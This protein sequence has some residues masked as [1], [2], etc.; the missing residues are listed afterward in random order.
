MAKK[1]LTIKFIVEDNIQTQIQSENIK[2]LEAIALLE[3]AKD[4]MMNNLRKGTKNLI[5]IQKKK[6]S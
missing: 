3:M 1:S 6:K 4:Q 5:N 2:P